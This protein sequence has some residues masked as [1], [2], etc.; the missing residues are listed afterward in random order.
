MKGV[1]FIYMRNPVSI[2]GYILAFLSLVYSMTKLYEVRVQWD[3]VAMG[4]AVTLL[5]V[6]LS[7][8][9]D[10]LRVLELKFDLLT[11]TLSE[12]FQKLSAIEQK[13]FERS[14]GFGS[15]PIRITIQPTSKVE[16]DAMDSMTLE[17]LEKERRKA[18]KEENYEK[19]A[20]IQKKIE[21][22]RRF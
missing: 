11:K 4:M 20:A 21:Q 12:T 17:E 18:E 1:I 5:F 10:Y 2:L 19:A 3:A 14:Y 16:S 9:F 7:L 6:L 8:I 15:A 13:N 22:R